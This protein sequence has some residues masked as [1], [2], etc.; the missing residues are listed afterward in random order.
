MTTKPSIGKN[1][2]GKLKI[3]KDSVLR[4]IESYYELKGLKV[5]MEKLEQLNELFS[6]EPGWNEASA[7]VMQYLTE[8]RKE[9]HK[10]QR[11]EKLEELRTAAPTI[12]VT[13]EAKAVGKTEVEKMDVEV[14]SPGNSIARII[15]IGDNKDDE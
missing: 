2:R 11:E 4:I 12:S 10:K 9:E 5:A 3:T 8:K 6:T 13:S 1:R 15:N 14:T 7:E